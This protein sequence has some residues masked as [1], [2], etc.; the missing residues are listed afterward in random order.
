LCELINYLHLHFL[1]ILL[2]VKECVD[3]AVEFEE[4]FD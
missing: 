4:N 2:D 3:Q 1:S